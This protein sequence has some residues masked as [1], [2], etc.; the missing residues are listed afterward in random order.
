M[1]S[2]KLIH[3][4]LIHINDIEKVAF[5]RLY[6]NYLKYN[7]KGSKKL[8]DIESTDQET[9]L[10]TQKPGQPFEGMVYTFI[11][12]NEKNLSE[13]ENLKTGKTFVF[14]DI[15]PM[16]FCTSFNLSTK[17]LKGLNLNMLP[18]GE[19]VKFFQAYYELYKNFLEN[20]EKL[21]ETNQVAINDVYRKAAIAG[22]NPLIFK[23]FNDTQHALFNYAYRSYNIHNI[24]NL[25]MI[26][27]EEWKY[28]PFLDAQQAFKKANL[29]II[30][31][32]YWENR[33][34]M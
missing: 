8:I 14:H 29:D 26:E 17:L 1:D 18:K 10:N 5:N 6:E 22:K 21:T 9:V 19:R 30:Y 24:R 7:L 28:I 3:E 15:I 13:L 16:V 23:R 31:R 34:K 32:T 27:Y 33:N 4:K 20:I 2:P 12:L 25:R 11:H